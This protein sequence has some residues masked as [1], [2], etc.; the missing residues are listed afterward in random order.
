MT[1]G[2]TE[3]RARRLA[4]LIYAAAHA[5][6]PGQYREMIAD[7]PIGIEALFCADFAAEFAP[8]QRRVSSTEHLLERNPLFKRVA[9]GG[10]RFEL[11]GLEGDDS[12]EERWNAELRA[13]ERRQQNKR[14]QL[15]DE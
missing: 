4:R 13:H 15:D 12:D 6:T 9:A 14:M 7:D 1:E 11:A 2:L 10:T 5:N 8:P 3:E